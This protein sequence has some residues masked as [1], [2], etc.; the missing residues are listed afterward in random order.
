[1]DMS[2]FFEKKN[3]SAGEIQT[4]ENE[5]EPDDKPAKGRAR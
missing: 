4:G 1:M 2:N 5:E 3:A